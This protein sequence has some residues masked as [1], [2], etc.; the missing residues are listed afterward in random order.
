MA[1]RIIKNEKGFSLLEVMIAL[2]M[3]SIFLAAYLV[4]QGGNIASSTLIQQEL[5]LKN[6]AEQQINMAILDP[7]AF[8]ESLNGKK[9]T[10]SFEDSQYSDYA[11]TIEFRKFEVPDFEEVLMGGGQEDNKQDAMDAIKK[12]VFK[13]LKDNLE[14]V[15]WQVKVTAFEKESGFNY[16]LSTW[17]INHDVPVRLNLSF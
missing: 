12:M 1:D 7:P 14:K 6:L 16:V 3:F 9:E 17:I 10:K 15:M 2:T 13:Q 4:S 8:T 11:Y 5:L